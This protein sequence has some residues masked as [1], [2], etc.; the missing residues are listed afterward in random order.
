MGLI[1]TIGGSPGSGK[2]TLGRMLAAH[3]GVPFF[4]MGEL[5]RK[6]ALE[7][8]M[9]INEL[10]V[11]AEKDPFSDK[12]VDEYQQTLAEKHE[13]FVIDSRLGFHFI[14]RSVKLFIHIKREIAAARIF[15]LRRDSEHWKSVEEGVRT[16]GEREAS[17]KLRYKHL[18][19]VDPSDLSQYD[20]VLDSSNT[21]PEELL[22]QV[23]AFLKEQNIIV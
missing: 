4:S 12:L 7:H 18:Y 5:R 21:T 13:S 11:K 3:L 6:Y 1:I 23:I 8:H 14:P 22:E 19:K 9:T 10:N 16:L 20:L 2:S 17:D 15:A